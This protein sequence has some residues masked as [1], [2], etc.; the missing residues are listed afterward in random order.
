M[1]LRLV[2]KKDE[3][4]DIHTFIFQPEEP[5]EWTPGQYM[6]YQLPHSGADDRGQER[7]F[8]ISSPPYEKNITITT[9][10]FDGRRSSFKTK[11]D[12]LK[13]GGELEADGPKG[14]FILEAG[15]H[16]HIFVAGGIGITPYHAMLEQFDHDGKMPHIELLYANQIDQLVFGDYF[17]SL[18]AK[19]PQF[20][21]HKFIGRHI[22]LPDFEQYIKDPKAIIYLSG[23]EPMVK[24]FQKM[25]SG[26][27][28]SE[29]RIRTDSF[30]GYKAF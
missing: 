30:P 13:V 12:S 23:P 4:A 22:E 26:A 17:K 7:W 11:L 8:T 3:I 14:K 24:N 19:Y 20:K 16:K 1:K 18:E 10:L 9:R 5:V 21:M 2:A 15:D 29:E 6:H 27:G 28:L 25:L